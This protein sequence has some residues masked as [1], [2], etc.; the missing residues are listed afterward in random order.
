[1]RCLCKNSPRARR[2]APRLSREQQRQTPGTLR[3]AIRRKKAGEIPF[4][5]SSSELG[6]CRVVP[7]LHF[8]RIVRDDVESFL[9]ARRALTREAL[10]IFPRGDVGSSS[11]RSGAS[12][13]LVHVSEIVTGGRV[14][15]VWPPCTRSITALY[16]LGR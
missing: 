7:Y 10:P 4:F 15:Q 8:S 1:M 9:L 2:R 16:V 11:S 14:R 12:Y 3:P 13:R 6:W 5:F